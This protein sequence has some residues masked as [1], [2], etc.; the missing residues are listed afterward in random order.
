M[1]FGR[2]GIAHLENIY[3]H[4]QK[5]KCLSVIKYTEIRKCFMSFCINSH[6]L[7]IEIGRYKKFDVKDR[8]CKV[9]NTG[10]VEVEQHL[11]LNCSAYHSLPYRFMEKVQKSRKIHHRT[12]N[13][14]VE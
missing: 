3:T 14:F 6:K 11:L 1:S 7:G 2:S 13:L 12:P 5:G 10:A 4:F 9:C 8:L